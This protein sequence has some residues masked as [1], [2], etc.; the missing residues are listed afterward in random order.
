MPK[1][2]ESTPQKVLRLSA[3]VV[4]IVGLLLMI[5]IVVINLQTK[6]PNPITLFDQEGV[7]IATAK[8]GEEI[9]RNGL[10]SLK[11]QNN[12]A[13]VNANSKVKV[14]NT[15]VQLLT[16]TALIKIN[17]DRTILQN[18][19]YADKAV[20]LLDNEN[21]KVY[22]V[23]GQINYQNSSLTAGSEWEYTEALVSAA[24]IN[25]SIFN[26]NAAYKILQEESSIVSNNLPW[27]NDFTAPK[28]V[29]VSPAPA[30]VVSTPQVKLTGQIDDSTAKI[31]VNSTVVTNNNSNFEITLQLTSG[32][33]LINVELT[34]IYGNAANNQL[35]I[36]YL[37]DA[38]TR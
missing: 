16:G 15:S 28:L 3:Y 32:S 1:Y 33:N 19:F 27:L 11:W 10:I 22:V 2:S 18:S 8:Y 20:I 21:N 12:V 36:N 23:E 13:L 24:P 26:S 30:S 35:R 34:D 25:R 31:K 6:Q 37:V 14:S 9:S 38:T 5:L 17:T 4:F 7:Q 29:N